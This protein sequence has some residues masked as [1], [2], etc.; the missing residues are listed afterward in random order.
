VQYYFDQN[1][2]VI[3]SQVGYSGGRVKNPTYEQICYENTGHAEVVVIEFDSDLVTYQ[4]LLKHFFRLHDPTQMNRQ[5]PDVG[6]QYRSVIFY[7]SDD[8]RVI[9]ESIKEQLQS[10]HGYKIVTQIEPEGPIYLAEDYHQKYAEKTGR[11]MCH[12]AYKPI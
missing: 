2:G 9:A 5:G 8:Q 4:T 11:G 7:T 6:E 1:P 3:T 10:Q 12:V